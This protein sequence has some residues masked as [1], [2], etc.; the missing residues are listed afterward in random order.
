MFNATAVSGNETVGAAMITIANQIG[1][2][3]DQ[4]YA[5]YLQVQ[6]AYS[7]LM[8]STVVI[9]IIFFVIFIYWLMNT[10]RFK[11]QKHYDDT[12]EM[13]GIFGSVLIVFA[14]PLLCWFVGSAIITMIFPQYGAMHSMLQLLSG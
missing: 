11:D 12:K 10:D 13:T 9:T 1:L 2:G 5:I 4:I 7:L 3:V 6:V 14:M 8:I